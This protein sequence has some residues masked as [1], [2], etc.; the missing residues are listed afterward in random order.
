MFKLPA[1]YLC[2]V[3]L[4]QLDGTKGVV[5]VKHR[6][7]NQ[8]PFNSMYF[9]VQSMAAELTT[10]AIVIKKI[11]E[12]NQ[13][14]SMLVTNHN[15]AFTKKA[16]GLITFTWNDGNLIDKAIHRTINTGEGE[17]IVMKSIGINEK[18][19]QVSVYEFEWS[20]KLKS[21]K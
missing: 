9:A 7:M 1:A 5:T 18:G 15:G 17:T 20:I 14:I 12:S 21:K 2:G 11:K 8:N 16:I 19:E 6:W 13:N 3:R 4:K 10:G